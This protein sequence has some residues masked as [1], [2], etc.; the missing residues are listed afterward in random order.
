MSPYSA[1][2]ARRGVAPRDGPYSWLSPVRASGMV[3]VLPWAAVGRLPIGMVGLALLLFIQQRTGDYADA[4]LAVGVFG[5]ANSV[6]AVVQ[7][8]LMDRHGVVGVTWCCGTVHGLAVFGVVAAGAADGGLAVVLVPAAL[9]GLT[10]PQISTA[11]R[12]LWGTLLPD[13]HARRRAY[14][15]ESVVVEG[16]VL[17]G[18]TLVSLVA[19]LESV[20]WALVVTALLCLAGTQGFALSA[21]TLLSVQ[22]DQASTA[23]L[24]GAFGAFGVHVLAMASFFSTG[25]CLGVLQIA[26]PGAVGG[27]DAAASAGYLLTAFGVGSVIGG[28]VYGVGRWRSSPP[29]RLMRLQVLLAVLVLPMA[30]VR[31]PAL[32][33]GALLVAGC[34][35]APVLVTVAVLLD[36][37]APA[38]TA[39]EAYTV[40]IT[41]N[42]LGAATGNAL[43]GLLL[44][45]VHSTAPLFLCAAGAPVLGAVV[46]AAGARAL[47]RPPTLEC[48]SR[49]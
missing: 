35:F 21:R 2:V 36:D 14:A 32:L 34:L 25:M 29:S 45:S 6:G 44:G 46:T 15:F 8:R 27:R 4:G 12:T 23:G 42:V 43:G 24:L 18:P 28:A 38:G 5:A 33:T 9:A 17:V 20:G 7:G 1:S 13:E 49:P 41:A 40:A 48:P 11:M 26:V 37:V 31:G 19:G 10:F 3:H 39:N 30:A 47:N 16:L 22:A